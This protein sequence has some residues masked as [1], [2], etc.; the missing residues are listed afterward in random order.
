MNVFF[1]SFCIQFSFLECLIWFLI[2][3][4]V[5]LH[6]IFAELRMFT[7]TEVTAHSFEP[8]FDSIFN[9]SACGW[10]KILLTHHWTISFHRIDWFWISKICFF[11]HFIILGQEIY[12]I[13]NIEITLRFDEKHLATILSTIS[14]WMF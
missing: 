3:N 10:N 11:L 4:F 5:F 2:E 1:S 9:F 6:K 14:R 7:R 8:Q 12:R 13:E